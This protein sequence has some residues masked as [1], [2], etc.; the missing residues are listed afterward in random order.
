VTKEQSLLDAEEQA[1]LL[2]QHQQEGDAAFLLRA[3]AVKEV[4][5]KKRSLFLALAEE[6]DHQNEIIARL[7]PADER[8]TT[9]RPS[10]RARIIAAL[11]RKLGPRRL[12]PL[13]AASKVRGHPMPV[14]V[15]EVGGRHA[16]GKGG[17]LRAAVFG[18]NDGL[19]SNAS[20]IMGMVGAGADREALL[21]TGVA[22]LLA[23]AFSMAA[24]EYISM[25]TQR[26]MFEHQIAL[27]RKELEL[28]PAEEAKELALIYEARGIP[29]E[30]AMAL[31]S[32]LVANP[33]VA[34]DV[35]AREE[36]GLNP[37]DLGS[38]TGA[39]LSS[40]L[41]FGV[42][43]LTPLAP[44]ALGMPAP[45]IGSAIFSGVGLIAVGAAMSLFS[46]RNPFLGG[47]RMVAIGAAAA[48]ATWLI[49][50]LLGVAVS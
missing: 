49:G 17:A 24:G 28:Y 32:R 5:P 14:S 16:T 10:R 13:L 20:L 4:D 26:E 11:V 22:G 41:A 43:A 3:L 23:G 27:E 8:T 6:G 15:E 2:A 50:S 29:K 37:D 45:V 34:L 38:A 30:E 12:L 40:F 21:L 46:G 33:E 7:L 44:I 42:G 47:A 36:L 1:K 39:A 19:V 25:R 48:C 18:V 35:L 31:A 9:F